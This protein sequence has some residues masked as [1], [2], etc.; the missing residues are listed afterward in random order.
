MRVLLSRVKQARVEVDNQITGQID[1]GFLLLVG[2]HTGDTIKDLEYC[3]DRVCK[4]RIFEDASGKMN[5]PP[6]PQQVAFLA[7][8]QF[9][10]YAD[11]S[12]RRP[13][14]LQAA[15]PDT[16]NA[17]FETFKERCREAGFRVESGVFGADMQVY[18]QNDG[19]VTIWIDSRTGDL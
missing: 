13:S 14:F 7:V 4:L 3:V 18:S 10:L 11:V 2:I 1:N 19:P 8:S 9:T 5:L 12:S 15:R 6:D 17:L 16:A